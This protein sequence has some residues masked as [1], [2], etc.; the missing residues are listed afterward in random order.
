VST[1]RITCNDLRRCLGHFATGVTV[2]TYWDEGKPRGATMNAFTSVSLDPPLV[3]ISV[4]RTAKSCAKLEGRPF[5]VNVLASDQLGIALQFAGKPGGRLDLRWDAGGI[6][7][8]LT[9][10]MAWLECTPW[11]SYD[12]GDHVL[13]LGEVQRLE[14]RRA[15][16]LLFFGGSFRSVGVELFHSPRTIM[17]DGRPIP[18]W[19]TVAEKIHDHV[20]LV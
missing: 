19:L 16:P 20:P 10:A 15:D 7:P 5:T 2:V 11:R 9:N 13:F 18:S 4:A 17:L 14:Y 6:A 12:G 1:D 3:L 8:H